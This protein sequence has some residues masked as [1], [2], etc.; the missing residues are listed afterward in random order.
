MFHCEFFTVFPKE[1]KD[2]PESWEELTDALFGLM[3][4]WFGLMQCSSLKITEQSLGVKVATF[5]LW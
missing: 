5:G 4:A 2:I 3:C 1:N